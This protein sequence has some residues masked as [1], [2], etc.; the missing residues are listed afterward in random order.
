[1]NKDYFYN[2][3]DEFIRVNKARARAGF[4]N[5]EVV[6]ITPVNGRPTTN[7]PWQLWVDIQ[8]DYVCNVGKSFDEIINEF[9]YYNCN[10]EVGRYAKYY[11]K[12]R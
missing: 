8:R 6:R 3:D 1:M 10:S 7:S 4:N 12:Q 2:G 5:G 9:E 11:M